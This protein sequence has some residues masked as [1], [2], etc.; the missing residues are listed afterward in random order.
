[1]L[2]PG[3]GIAVVSIVRGFA[4]IVVRTIVVMSRPIVVFGV[5]STSPVT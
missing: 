5:V 1:M 4:R 2:V 3:V